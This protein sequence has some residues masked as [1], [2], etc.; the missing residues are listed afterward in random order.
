MPVMYNPEPENEKRIIAHYPKVE[1][2][3]IEHHYDKSA[4]KK[5]WCNAKIV[6]LCG[7]TKF[8]KEFQ[9]A[10]IELGLKGEIVLTVV[11]FNHTDQ[12]N[13][14]EEQK[15]NLDKLHFEKIKL[16]DYIY[17]INVGDYIG[18]STRNEITFA[19][20]NNTLVVYRY[21]HQES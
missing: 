4:L 7:S 15:Q 17:V 9:E 5:L 16:A 19:K 10:E 11:G 21:P 2:H 12:L 8:K 20:K 1:L 3:P 18:E 14:T 13:Y 6:C